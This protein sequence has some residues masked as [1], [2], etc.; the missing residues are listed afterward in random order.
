MAWNQ[1]NGIK[2]ICTHSHTLTLTQTIRGQ[3]LQEKEDPQ[4]KIIIRERMEDQKL[5]I[6]CIWNALKF[7]CMERQSRWWWWW[8]CFLVF[9]PTT[10]W[11]NTSFLNLGHTGRPGITQHRLSNI[12]HKTDR[13]TARN[14]LPHLSHAPWFF[15]YLCKK[16]L[17]IFHVFVSLPCLLYLLLPL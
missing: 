10:K 12:R 8:G 9:G 2:N 1:M 4:W 17:T 3:R 14:G 11:Q 7:T 5:K 16:R 6:I 15:C 13:Q